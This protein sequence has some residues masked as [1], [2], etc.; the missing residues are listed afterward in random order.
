MSKAWERIYT[1]EQ[2]DAIERATVDRGLSGAE[3]ARRCKTGELQPGLE[4]FDIPP[5]TVRDFKRKALS[6]RRG[7]ERSELADQPATEAIEA[8]RKRLVSAADLELEMVERQQR[9][10]RSGPGSAKR[11]EDHDSALRRAERMRQ[12]ARA[13]REA[14][15]IPI[16][17]T[18]TTVPG[19]HNP[20]TNSTEGGKPGD[21]TLAGGILAAHTGQTRNGKPAPDSV[22]PTMR[23]GSHQQTQEERERPREATEQASTQTDERSGGSITDELTRMVAR[24]GLRTQEG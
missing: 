22:P 2:R 8:L 7:T 12:I 17:G 6:R 14:A 1:D 20:K 13:V 5:N 18:S 9:G 19:R 15:A 21:R 16:P 24:A 10:L 4:P 11:Q 23:D 3:V